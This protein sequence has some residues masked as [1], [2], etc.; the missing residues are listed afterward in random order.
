MRKSV[1]QVPTAEWANK[2]KKKSVGQAPTAERVKKRKK[3]KCRTS[4]DIGAE[5]ENH[6]VGRDPT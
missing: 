2:R 1:G 5:W 6:N 4:P 3:K